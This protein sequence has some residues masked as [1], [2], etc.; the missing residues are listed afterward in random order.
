[1]K[2]LEQDRVSD[3]QEAETIRQAQ[4]GDTDAFEQLYRLH[5]SRV[6]ALCLRML[7]QTTEAEDLTQQTFLTIFRA[8]RTFRGEC[9]F[10]SW[11]HRITMNCV[12]MH[13]R[14]KVSHQ[15]SLEEIVQTAEESGTT[16]KE[17]SHYDLRLKGLI[18]R[19]SIEKAIAQ[20][21]VRMRRTFVLYDVWAAS[22]ER[23]PK[24]SLARR[25][26]PSR[27]YIRLAAASANYCRNTGRVSLSREAGPSANQ[28]SKLICA[29]INSLGRPARREGKP[30]SKR[31]EP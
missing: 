14:K 25:A 19:L 12:L 3:S 11:L 22:T 5:S 9:A 1:M 27:D 24:S 29:H 17:L 7:K 23:S 20:L 26:L 15:V 30:V 8:I 28:P 13:L 31:S 18:D 16:R 4:R 10:S 21:S 2:G 6:F